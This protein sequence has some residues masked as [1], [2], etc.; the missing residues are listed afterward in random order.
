MGGPIRQFPFRY[1]ATYSMLTEAPGPL[2]S[3]SASVMGLSGRAKSY[4]FSFSVICDRDSVLFSHEFL[5][6]PESLSKVHASVCMNME[7]SLSLPLIEQNVH[8]TV[9]ADGKSVG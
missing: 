2:P 7:P 1:W 8:P 4:H 3:R 6:V 5:I 9:W